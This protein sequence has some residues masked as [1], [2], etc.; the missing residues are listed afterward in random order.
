MSFFRKMYRY[1][2]KSLSKCFFDG[3]RKSRDAGAGSTPLGVKRSSAELQK[4]QLVEQ[5]N[6]QQN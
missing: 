2:I 1:G 4:K 6:G 5:V 3:D